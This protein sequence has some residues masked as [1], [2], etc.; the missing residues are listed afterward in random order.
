MKKLVM[1]ALAASTV[2]ATPVAAQTVTGTVD[3]TGS[4]AP[5]CLVVP[6]AGSTFGATVALGELAQADGTMR[7]DLSSLFSSVGGVGLETR[8]VCTTANPTI[9][10]N[11]TPLATAATADTGYDNSIDFRARVLVDTTTTNDVLFTNDS[12]D[13][14]GSA[15]LIGGR[16]A[17]NSGNNIKIEADMFRTGALTD[18]LV[19]SPTYTGQIV[20]VIAPG[21]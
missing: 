16:L 14:D 17:N 1:I 3:I 13:P 4:V 5:K 21:S 10:V 7:T 11:A 8:V 15:V 18:L 2:I 9:A 6:G 12:N 20:V 19:A